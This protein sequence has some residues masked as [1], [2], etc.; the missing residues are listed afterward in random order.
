MIIYLYEH[1]NQTKYYH[2]SL[3]KCLIIYQIIMIQKG[4]SIIILYKDWFSHPS[5]RA[6][7]IQIPDI[8]MYLPIYHHI[9]WNELDIKMH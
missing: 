9:S 8:S 6:C 7:Y 2:Y 5:L 3:N 1:Q 4:Q